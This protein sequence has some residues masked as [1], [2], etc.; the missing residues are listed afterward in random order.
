MKK[1]FKVAYVG[2]THLGLNYLTATAANVAKYH[3]L[4]EHT[5]HTKFDTIL[6]KLCL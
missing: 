5:L 6:S 2:L 3:H 4:D 1:S